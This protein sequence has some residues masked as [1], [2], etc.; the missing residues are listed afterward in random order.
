MAR[1]P[2][3]MSHYRTFVGAF[4]HLGNRQEILDIQKLDRGYLE[5]GQ[6]TD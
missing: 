1:D 3:R 2:F 6:C 4:K 5:V